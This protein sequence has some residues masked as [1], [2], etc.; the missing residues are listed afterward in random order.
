MSGKG[1][2]TVYV[3]P[4]SARRSFFEKLFGG[5]PTHTPP[6]LGIDQD[7]SIVDANKLGNDLLRAESAGGIQKGDPGYFPDGV[8]MTFTGAKAS[9]QAPNTAE[10]KDV[11]WSS[12]GGPANSYVP[13]I[14]SPGPGKTDGTD[15]AVD[16]KITAADIKPSYVPAAPGTGTKSPTASSKKVSDASTLG[17][18]GLKPGDSGANS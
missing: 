5:D 15:K 6:F 7:K 17:G 2:Y 3:P 10:G 12:A 9:I 8:D 18:T 4:K 13:D 14:T 11:V 1:K 16:P